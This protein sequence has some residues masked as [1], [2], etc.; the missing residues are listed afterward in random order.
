MKGLL[1]AAQSGGENNSECAFGLLWSHGDL[2][3]AQLMAGTS[4]RLPTQLCFLMAEPR[5]REDDRGFDP[6]SSSISH[7]KNLFPPNSSIAKGFSQPLGD[8][9]SNSAQML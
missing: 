9:T 8:A 5:G 3:W 4:P 6:F 1:R 2:S 7:P